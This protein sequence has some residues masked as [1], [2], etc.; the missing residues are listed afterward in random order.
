MRIG[1]IGTGFMA[2]QVV[3]T[4]AGDGH[5]ICVSPRTRA[6]AKGLAAEFD[7][8]TIADNQAVLDQSDVILVGLLAE[9]AQQLLPGLRFRAEHKVI[10]LMAGLRQADLK[11]LVAP[12]RDV[13]I[14][15]PFPFVAQGGA[16]LLV[17][18]ET[19]VVRALLGGHCALICPDDEAVF[20]SYLAAQAV[21]SPVLK[22]LQQSTDWLAGHGA[23]SDDAGRFLQSLV[24]GALT[25]RPAGETGIF[26]AM[27]DELNT[28]GGLNAELREHMVDAGMI[29]ALRQG[30]DQ[31]DARLNG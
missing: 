20:N 12:V 19:D 28:P 11:A 25:A 8:V 30:L 2:A 27:L 13:A 16:P 14:A 1:V 10:S 21:L 7:S 23:D 5:E 9:V 4:V 6:R 26:T 22:L 18:P 17:Y 15:I 24:A 31:L 29:R 3:R